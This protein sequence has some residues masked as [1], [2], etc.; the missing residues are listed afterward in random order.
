MFRLNEADLAQP[1][2]AFAIACYILLIVW[3]EI[4]KRDTTLTS[5]TNTLSTDERRYIQKGRHFR[6]LILGALTLIL[7]YRL[8]P[9]IYKYV[10]PIKALDKSVINFFGMAM[11]LGSLVWTSVLQLEFDQ[12]LYRY[13]ALDSHMPVADM[14]TY[15]RR[16][17]TGY[18]ILIFSLTL[19]LASVASAALLFIACHL[20]SRR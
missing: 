17:Q 16:I 7:C 10:I 18:F 11:L 9:V 13:K 5:L 12:Q 6:L 19:T 1:L 8:D 2:F 15:S 4:R 20:Q 14:I 3:A